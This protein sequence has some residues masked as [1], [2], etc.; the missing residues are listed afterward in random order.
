M[1]VSG[2]IKLFIVLAIG[3]VI[4]RLWATPGNMVGLP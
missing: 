4:G 2:W 1:K 3:Y